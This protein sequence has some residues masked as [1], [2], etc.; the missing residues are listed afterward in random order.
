MVGTYKALF[1]G[2][3]KFGLRGEA[4]PQKVAAAILDD[5]HAA[6]S[7][8]RDSFTLEVKTKDN[9]SRYSELVDLFRKSFKDIDKLGTLED[10]VSGS[11]YSI[12]EVAYWAWHEQLDAVREQLKFDSEC[13][14]KD[15]CQC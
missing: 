9:Y 4:N 1:N 11:D 13:E 2:K 15:E 6:F 12:L 7:V 5:A 3:S 8:V 10:I 14:N